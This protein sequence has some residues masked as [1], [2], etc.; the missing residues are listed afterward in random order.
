MKLEH[1]AIWTNQ[2][3]ALKEYY[4]KYFDAVP[5][6]KYANPKTGFQSYFLTFSS[7]ARIELM[8]KPDIPENKNDVEDTQIQT[9]FNE[10][11]PDDAAR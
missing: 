1:V 6:K 10:N 3:E 7:G 9:T 4:I 8:E 11:S 2:L 5:N